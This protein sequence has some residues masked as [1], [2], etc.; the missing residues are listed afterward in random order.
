MK[1]ASGVSFL[2]KTT[3]KPPISTENIVRR[4][5]KY[6]YYHMFKDFVSVALKGVPRLA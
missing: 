6:K 1:A 5:I 2:K 3:A 4:M